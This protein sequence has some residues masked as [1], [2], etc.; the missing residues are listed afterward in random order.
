MNREAFAAM[1][2]GIVS[3][4]IDLLENLFPSRTTIARFPDSPTG[5]FRRIGH[6]TGLIEDIFVTSLDRDSLHESRSQFGEIAREKLPIFARIIGRINAPD[7]GPRIKPATPG[8]LHDP[9]QSAAA[10]HVVVLKAPRN[11]PREQAARE[12]PDQCKN[13]HRSER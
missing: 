5:I 2:F 9:G 13:F 6:A 1:T 12:T 11:R 8:M 7:I 4:E 3:R 10:F